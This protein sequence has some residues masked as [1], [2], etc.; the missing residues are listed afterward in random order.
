MKAGVW[1]F[2]SAQKV[3][4]P[5]SK[6]DKKTLRT[7][8]GLSGSLSAVDSASSCDVKIG[9][10]LYELDEEGAMSWLYAC[11]SASAWRRF[12]S[13]RYSGVYPSLALFRPKECM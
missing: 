3:A 9:D 10:G 7:K 12:L 5:Q 1:K 11:S 8:D 6:M 4:K 2:F 13:A